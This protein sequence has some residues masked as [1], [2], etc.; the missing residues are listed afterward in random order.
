MATIAVFGVGFVGSTVANYLEKQDNKI[1]RVDINLHPDTDPIKAIKK[2]DGVIIC[3]PTPSNSDGSC[4]DS[5]VRTVLEL[6]KNKTNILLKSTVTF[7]CMTEY[8]DNVVYNPEFLREMFAEKDFANQKQLVFGAENKD[9]I[10]FWENLFDNLECD[11]IKTNRTTASMIKYVHN[12][13]L[14]TKVAFFHE[15]FQN[16][17]KDMH[18]GT[19]TTTLARMP[20]IGAT[21]M[22]VPNLDG[23]LGY[24]G[25]CFPKD[26]KALTNVL[27]HSILNTVN[28][29]NRG[30][31]ETKI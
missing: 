29:T 16:G 4:D 24:G 5:I 27:E 10:D 11:V 22:I 2:C 3:V 20:T 26:I 21:H 18:Y 8:S 7:N 13:W 23:T 19:V 14:A 6:A 12:G 25:N 17:P 9:C 15:L 30:L 1:I 28:S 31:N